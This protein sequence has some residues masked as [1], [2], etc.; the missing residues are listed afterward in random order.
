MGGLLPGQEPTHG[1]SGWPPALQPLDSRDASEFAPRGLSPVELVE[2]YAVLGGTPQYQRWAGARPLGEI[3][4]D[5]ILSPDAPLHRD[6]EHLVREED[7]IRDPGPYFGTL[8]AIAAG[9][10]P[11][12]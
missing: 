4:R 9:N 12:Y 5:V 2:R 11:P 7:E 1:R 6:P 10:T 8:E 3:L